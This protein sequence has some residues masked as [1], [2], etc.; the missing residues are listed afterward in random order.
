MRESDRLENSSL[1]LF[2]SLLCCVLLS[3]HLSLVIGIDLRYE[4][5]KCW[6]E[7]IIFNE[8]KIICVC[9]DRSG[10]T[11]NKEN[12]T[13]SV[14]NIVGVSRLSF[15]CNLTSRVFRTKN[16]IFSISANSSRRL[17]VAAICSFSARS[18]LTDMTSLRSIFTIITCPL[19]SPKHFSLLHRRR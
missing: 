9:L 1:S 4:L 3:N 6:G 19:S 14:R 16:V 18:P 12:C 11:I 8:I 7:N 17:V 15:S 13:S 10:F 2:S 5:I